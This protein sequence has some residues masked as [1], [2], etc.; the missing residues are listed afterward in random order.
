[1]PG[2]LGY[3][4]MRDISVSY[5]DM[6]S[7]EKGVAATTEE[8]YTASM[9]HNFTNLAYA[10]TSSVVDYNLKY[11]YELVRPTMERLAEETVITPNWAVL[12]AWKQSLGHGR[13][14]FVKTF[15]ALTQLVELLHEVDI[16]GR[17]FA[18][19]AF[20]FGYKEQ[21][22]V[23]EYA[24]LDAEVATAVYNDTTY[25]MSTIS[26]LYQWYRAFAPGD[27]SNPAYRAI[28]SHFSDQLPDKFTN[29]TMKAIIGPK[30]MMKYLNNTYNYRV[31]KGLNYD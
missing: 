30:S 17:F 10:P 11:E 27:M 15:Q 31:G 28:Q 14:N 6:P 4:F 2:S 20:H 7:L 8:T 23:Q 24:R 19:N 12:S 3:T 29:D 21:A 25:G 18:F 16:Y 26:G 13:A 5:V 9:K 1:M 22:N